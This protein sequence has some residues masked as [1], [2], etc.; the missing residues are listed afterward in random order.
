M[1]AIEDRA[2]SIFLA[3]V[4]RGPSEWPTFLDEACSDDAELRVRVDQLLHSHQ[5]M[6]SVHGGAATGPADTTD[7]PRGEGAGKTIGPYKLLEQIGEGGM[8]TVYMAQ[9]TEPVKRAV[10]LKIIKAGMDTRQV[11]AR[12]E[13][14]RQ[15]LRPDGPSQ[16]RQGPRRR[17]DRTKSEIRN[18]KLETRK[19]RTVR[20][21][22]V[23][24]SNFVLR[25]FPVVAPTS[26]WSWSRASRSPSIAMNIG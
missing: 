22:L 2:R 24:I 5:A 8:G 26:S 18:S 16:H 21:L 20:R 19:T 1:N 7:F 14:E 9:Q 11:I 12:F 23:R 17:D 25:I 13:A 3:A 15:A 4:E 10:A 6:G